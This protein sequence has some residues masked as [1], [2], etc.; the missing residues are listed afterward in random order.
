[1]C[2]SNRNDSSKTREMKFFDQQNIRSGK[3]KPRRG[4]NQSAGITIEEWG[5]SECGLYDLS[6][7]GIWNHVC[8]IRWN[9]EGILP[10][11]ELP[12]KTTAS[13]SFVQHAL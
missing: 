3:T 2:L 13:R 8:R 1:M 10:Q 5:R 4:S 12:S 9:R 11:M 7:G 6:E